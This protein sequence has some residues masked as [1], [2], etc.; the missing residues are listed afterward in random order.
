MTIHNNLNYLYIH[1]PDAYDWPAIYTNTETLVDV[2]ADVNHIEDDDP[3][4]AMVYRWV[5]GSY[6]KQKIIDLTEAERL[7]EKLIIPIVPY[8]QFHTSMVES[9]RNRN[10]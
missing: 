7:G 1:F 4:I 8:E 2:T 5:W 3:L 9:F 6:T 10:G